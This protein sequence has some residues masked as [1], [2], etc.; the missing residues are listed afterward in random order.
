M[1]LL[2]Y[3]QFYYCTLYSCRNRGFD[4]NDPDNRMLYGVLTGIAVVG[5]FV[6]YSESYQEVTWKEFINNYLNHNMVSAVQA[7]VTTNVTPKVSVYA[8]LA[9]H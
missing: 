1:E 2:G 3:K 7:I 9:R 8:F 6:L 5:F 4:P